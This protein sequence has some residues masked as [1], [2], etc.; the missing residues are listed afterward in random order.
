MK[1]TDLIFALK[2]RRGTIE[3]FILFY[4]ILLIV[5]NYLFIFLL[6]SLTFFFATTQCFF[7]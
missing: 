4:I 2:T 3:M 7:L 5:V 6:L 1:L